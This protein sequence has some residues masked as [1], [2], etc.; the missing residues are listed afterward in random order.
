MDFINDWT[1]LQMPEEKQHNTYWTIHFDGSRQLEGS[2]AG[3]VLASPRGDK[4][5]Y[6]LRLMFPC[7][8]N[9]AEYE[10]LLHRLQMAKEMNLSRVR[11]FGDSDLVAQ[12]VSGTWDSKDPLM[13][14]YRREVDVIA[15][16]FNGY[17]VEHADRMK[18]EAADALSWLGSQCKLVPP[19]VFPDVLHNPSVKLP[20]KEDL[21]V[22]DP[23]AQLVAALHVIPDWTL[24]F[25][26]Y[27]TRG[28]LPEDETLARQVTRRSKSMTISDGEIYHRSVTEA[29]QRCVSPEE[30]QEILREIHEGDCGHH[31]GSKSLV[32]KAFRH[33]FY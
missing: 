32:A 14:A 22:P 31:A 21:A 28:E 16:H 2:V 13:A 15:G 20:T 4:F 17:E 12:Q 27:M 5:G 30:G 8:N 26:A 19:N 29:F 33:G 18:N 6:V 3:V 7:T 23:E 24:L 9:A 10:A 11:C 1:E 25:L